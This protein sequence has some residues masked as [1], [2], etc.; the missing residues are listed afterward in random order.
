MEEELERRALALAEAD[1]HKD[2]FLAMLG[3]ELRN[4][5]GAINNALYLLEQVGSMDERAVR[6][7]ATAIRQVRHL[8]RL[9]EDLLDISRISRG[10]ITLHPR[11]VDLRA[12]AESAVETVRPLV[13]SRR[14]RLQVELPP[15]PLLLE[16]DPDRV[17]QILTNL[18][19]NAV[20]YTEPKGQIWLS[21][22]RETREGGE[23]EAVIRVRDTGMGMPPDLLP[24]VFDLFAQSDA[25]PG[26]GGLGLGLTLVRRLVEMH[27]G[28]VH[29]FSPGPGEGSE[30]TVRLPVRV[31]G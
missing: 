3:H 19:S 30:F 26:H 18:L 10:K 1:R 28:T 23:A 25:S 4:P 29:A 2:E 16:A 7:R 27:G 24:R 13:E 31:S 5:L 6:H 15:E 14:H 17:E 21:L 9:V 22:A 12:C 11:E 20:R 8:T